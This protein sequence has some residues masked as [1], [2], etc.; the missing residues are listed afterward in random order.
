[1][2]RTL[3]VALG[4]AAALVTATVA[5]ALV[6]AV[7]GANE[8]TATF[9]T[10]TI[11]KSKVRSCTADAKTWES[12]DGHYSGTV[13]SS[14]VVL[15]GSLKIHAH[16]TY[17]TTDKL[18]YVDGSFTIKDDD[19]RVKGKFSGT[20]KDGKLVGYL[21][22]KSRGSHAK[23]LGNLSADFAGGATNFSN[24]QIGAGS[25]T[26]VLAVV[27]GPVCKAPKAEHG[28]KAERSKQE[29]RA[30]HVEAK[31]EI[32]ALSGDSITVTGRKGPV[33]CKVDGSYAVP[34]GAVLGTKNVEI[35]CEAVGDPAVW[36]LRKLEK[37]S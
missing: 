34:A 4:I 23:V 32:A 35:K 30:R 18:G 19:S 6:P 20:I 21:T 16:T 15:A 1:M 28:K 11:D 33:T 13:V 29:K 7:V 5:F 36:T 2:R 17:S 9:S 26:A 12:T 37:D 31:G 27:A 25:S 24:G 10:A 14:N 22:G 8:A 3:T